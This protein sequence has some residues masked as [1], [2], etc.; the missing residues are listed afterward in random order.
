MATQESDAAKNTVSN[1]EVKMN[2]SPLTT[3]TLRVPG[4]GKGVA[5][6]FGRAG[7]PAPGYVWTRY[8]TLH[9]P[10]WRC[11]CRLVFKTTSRGSPVVSGFPV[12]RPSG[13]GGNVSP[14][15]TRWGRGDGTGNRVQ[16][17]RC[18]PAD[19]C[20]VSEP[21][22]GPKLSDAARLQKP[23]QS[24]AAART[25]FSPTATNAHL[26]SLFNVWLDVHFVNPY[27]EIRVYPPAS[28]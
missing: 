19:C 2:D 9:E 20:G 1:G 16:G 14:G 8:R 22:Q 23:G 7:S 27:S 17:C 12:R 10:R 26:V 25:H 15:Y 4:E 18:E 11:Q 21:P 3:F 5:G 13:V 6:R 24:P 28:C